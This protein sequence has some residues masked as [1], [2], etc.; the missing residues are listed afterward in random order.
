MRI[1]RIMAV[2][3]L[4]PATLLLA[5]A[6]PAHATL[7]CKSE[8]CLQARDINDIKLDMKILQVSAHFPRGLTPIG[9]RQYQAKAD[10]VSYD[11]EF[12]ARGHLFRIDSSEPLGHFVPTR[13]FGLQLTRKLEAKYGRF[14]TDTLPDGAAESAF[15][16]YCTTNSG[17]RVTCQTESLNVMLS[18]E[19]GQPVKLDIQLMDFRILRRDAAIV[20]APSEAQ[21]ESRVHF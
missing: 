16:Q 12:S 14:E 4:F 18:K 10:G 1:M 8:S 5:G 13:A 20:N 6:L 11:L 19:F 21:A 3:G 17:T 15:A 7:L 9:G 2:L